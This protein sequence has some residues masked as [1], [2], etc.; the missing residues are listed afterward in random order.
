MNNTLFLIE[1]EVPDEIHSVKKIYSNPKII[2]L[3]YHA[4]RSLDKKNIVHDFGDKYLSTDDKNKINHLSINAAINWQKNLLNIEDLQIDNIDITKFLEFE[5]LQYFLPIYR[6]AFSIIRIIE[7]LKPETVV[8]TSVLNHFIK[9]ICIKNKINFVPL[10]ESK[11][12]TLE[13]D[14]INIK[15]DILNFPISFTVS[16]KF[17]SKLKSVT[18]KISNLFLKHGYDLT[19]KSILLLD[20]NPIQYEKLLSELTKTDQNILLLNQRRP[21]VWNKQSFKIMKNSNVRIVN[22]YDYKKSNNGKIKESLSH[23][24][25]QIDKIFTNDKKFQIFFEIN[26][27]SI[28]PSIQQS[29]F[30]ICRNRLAE[31]T[32]RIILLKEF[33]KKN[34]VSVILEWAELSQEEKE[35]LTIAKQNNIPSVLLQHAMYPTSKIWEPF[36][37]FA[38]TYNYPSE[39]DIQAVWGVL[40]KKHA[41]SLG[42]N[43]NLVVTGSPRHDNFFMYKRKKKSGKILL[44]TTVI[45]NYDTNYSTI[46]YY[47]KFNEFVKEVCRVIKQFP[48]KE[49]IVKPHPVNDSLNNIIDV[50]HEIDPKIQITHTQN[51]EK[52]I[53]DCELV[54]TFNNSTIAL[55]SIILGVPTITLEVEEWATDI[56]IVNDGAILAISDITKIESGIKKILNDD[57]FRQ[58]FLDSS[59]KFV[60]NYMSNQGN[61]SSN[62]SKLLSDF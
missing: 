56:S 36:S 42:H 10:S 40:S 22:L 61:A 50:L 37:R 48:D 46:D 38:L 8:C 27:I 60:N 28:W 15:Y 14:K 43:K 30:N 51:I 59:K 3:N 39:S 31:S 24:E 20:F 9:E 49:L 44:A 21:A 12:P 18:S 4:H 29:F 58:K 32:T 26:S 34:N 13:Y 52:L 7:I 53:A 16:R 55:E 57:D 45:S 19:T 1:D 11:Q 35:V 2:S 5:L 47:V 41:E 62:I 17:F 6:I 54:I 33:F 23:L 25:K